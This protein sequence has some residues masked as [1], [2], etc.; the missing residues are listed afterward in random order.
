MFS[1][2]QSELNFILCLLLVVL[3][4]SCRQKNLLMIHSLTAISGNNL[5]DS[6]LWVLM[7]VKVAKKTFLPILRF[8]RQCKDFVRLLGFFPAVYVNAH[9]GFFLQLLC[10]YTFR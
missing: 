10:F 1:I 4:Q 8:L 2:L 6:C 7:T 3:S 9:L 5:C